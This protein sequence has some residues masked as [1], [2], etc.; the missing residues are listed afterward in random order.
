MNDDAAAVQALRQPTDTLT[1]VFT[2]TMRDTAG[3]TSTATLT[4]TIQGANDAPV[5]AAQTGDQTA[6]VGSAFTLT[7]PATTFT[8]VDS[9]DTR[10][11]TAT[12]AD[13]RR[14]RPGS[15]STPATR[16]FSGTPAAANVGT[17]AVK[18]TA[19][20]IGGLAPARPS[21]SP[22]PTR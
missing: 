7:L 19:T 10:T 6:A 21:T 11:Y 18:V 17:Q 22:S 1:D 4:V 13:G 9:G 20:D 3:A 5:L 16:T 2:Y 8:D 12:A 15:P 14:C